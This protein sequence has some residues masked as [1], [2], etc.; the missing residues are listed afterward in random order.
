MS[1][2]QAL[3]LGHELDAQA[4]DGWPAGYTA[5]AIRAQAIAVVATLDR[6]AA[7][8]EQ[9]REFMERVAFLMPKRASSVSAEL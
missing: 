2:G 8:P 5:A 3:T 7:S 4:A 9:A 1:V 6:A